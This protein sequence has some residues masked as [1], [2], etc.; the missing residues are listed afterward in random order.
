MSSLASSAA[1]AAFRPHASPA[2]A[3]A[4]PSDL[5]SQHS[6]SSL[7]SS[8]LHDAAPAADG[9][10]KLTKAQKKNLKRAEKKARQ[11]AT[12]DDVAAALLPA[13]GATPSPLLQPCLSALARFRMLCCLHDLVNMGFPHWLCVAAIQ[14]TGTDM[15]AACEWIVDHASLEGPGELQEY[16]GPA[17]AVDVSQ[18]MAAIE[19]AL[20]LLPLAPFAVHRAVVD[21]HGNLYEALQA[22]AHA[23]ES[24]ACGRS[25]FQAG[26]GDGGGVEED[27]AGIE[28][29]LDGFCV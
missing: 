3:S 27:Q 4:A 11:V 5:S 8:L 19:E 24:G 10:T 14:R 23:L 26:G 20:A 7:Q 9:D 18:E 15:A 6:T 16:A 22:V 29:L 28:Q 21:A 17:M 12:A 2:F 1:Q 13:P 25:A